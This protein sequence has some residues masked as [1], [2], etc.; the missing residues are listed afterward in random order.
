MHFKLDDPDAS[1][2]YCPENR[3]LNY[4]LGDLGVCPVLILIAWK[5][6]CFH[7]VSVVTWTKKHL[8]S[9]TD[10]AELIHKLQ[11]IQGQRSKQSL[12]LKEHAT[13]SFYNW[14][15]TN[16]PF[17]MACHQTPIWTSDQPD[18]IPHC[19]WWYSDT[20]S[21]FVQTSPEFLLQSYLGQQ[22]ENLL[23]LSE[24]VEWFEGSSS[25][26]AI[27]CFPPEG[28]HSFHGK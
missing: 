9:R 6:I 13:R 26:P 20:N 11:S 1:Q 8:Q 24:S 2:Q 25:L 28:S 14:E 18:S 7:S 3:K 12:V 4:H 27:H 19:L 15:Q 21:V 23:S 10:I 16:C 22:W 5:V 17:N